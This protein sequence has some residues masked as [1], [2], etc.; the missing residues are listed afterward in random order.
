MER[1]T[2]ADIVEDSLLMLQ[3]P[4]GAVVPKVCRYVLE[5]TPAIKA[6]VCVNCL[7]NQ[8][9]AVHLSCHRSSAIT[10]EAPARI[11]WTMVWISD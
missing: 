10:S 7:L 8:S 5:R 11:Y 1:Y 2:H 3:R 9:V 6:T 4:E